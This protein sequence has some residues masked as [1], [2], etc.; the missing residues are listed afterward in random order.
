MWYCGILKNKTGK[1][2]RSYTQLNISVYSVL[3]KN[4]TKTEHKRKHLTNF[5]CS[6]FTNAVNNSENC[7]KTSIRTA[8]VPNTSGIQVWSIAASANLHGETKCH[9]WLDMHKEWGNTTAK[10]SD[11]LENK[12]MHGHINNIVLK[13]HW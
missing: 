9:N 3:I 2:S 4:Y 1:K 5:I 12:K 6:L 11:S 10:T 8:G 13:W 7:D